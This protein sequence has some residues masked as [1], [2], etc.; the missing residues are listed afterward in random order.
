METDEWKTLGNNGGVERVSGS[1]GD[2]EAVF[3]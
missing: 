3:F 1:L 2:I